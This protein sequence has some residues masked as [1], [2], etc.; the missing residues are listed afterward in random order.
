MLDAGVRSPD[1]MMASFGTHTCSWN[2]G[3][4][5]ACP[6]AI[7][8]PNGQ[9]AGDRKKPDGKKSEAVSKHEVPPVGT[10]LELA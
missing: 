9:R 7:R 5:G 4:P 3:W 2:D 10:V 8:T 6:R 1:L